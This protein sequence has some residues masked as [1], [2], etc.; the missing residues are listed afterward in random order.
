MTWT[1]E[2]A[3]WWLITLVWAGEMFY[4]STPMFGTSLSLSLLA[5]IFE[6]VHLNVSA[7][8]LHLLNTA[9]RKSAHLAE[10]AMLSALLYGSLRGRRGWN[11]QP[12]VARGC[13]V[14]AAVYSFTD[15][16]HQLFSPGRGPS[17]IDCGIDACGAVMG[18]LLIYWRAR[19]RRNETWKGLASWARSRTGRESRSVGP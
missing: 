2:T 7:P 14:V 16:F 15:E 4:L 6:S 13:L 17:L 18:I 12:R 9:M 1:I 11:W 3:L 5:V 19:N 10:Y 8:T